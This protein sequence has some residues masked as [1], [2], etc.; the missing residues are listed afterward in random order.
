MIK[1][2]LY[3]ELYATNSQAKYEAF[4][5]RLTLAAEM[6]V[7]NIILQTDSQVVLSQVKRVT[8]TKDPSLQWYT[9]LPL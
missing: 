7:E 8:Q 9:A 5:A 3:F 1:V 6:G 4:I 2:S